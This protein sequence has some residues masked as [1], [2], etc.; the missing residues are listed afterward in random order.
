MARRMEA[1]LAANQRLRIPHARRAAKAIAGSHPRSRAPGSRICLR[2]SSDLGLTPV[3]SRQ[4][5]LPISSMKESIS[6]GVA[7]YA[8]S[9]DSAALSRALHEPDGH[10]RSGQRAVHEPGHGEPRAHRDEHTTD[11]GTASPVFDHRRRLDLTLGPPLAKTASLR[12]SPRTVRIMTDRS[13]WTP[14]EPGSA[15]QVEERVTAAVAG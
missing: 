10:R 15:A 8:A 3:C 2:P 14:W 7:R 12:E 4:S 1:R 5:G 6:S 13:R 11:R 9:R